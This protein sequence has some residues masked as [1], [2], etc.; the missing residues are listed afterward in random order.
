MALASN[1]NIIKWFRFDKTINVKYLEGPIDGKGAR[2]SLKELYYK[3]NSLNSM[4][5]SIFA[6]TKY[7]YIWN[8][9]NFRL[10]HQNT[11]D[12]AIHLLK[13]INNSWWNPRKQLITVG[14]IYERYINN[15]AFSSIH[16][17]VVGFLVIDCLV[18][19][20]THKNVKT[21]HF[22][23]FYWCF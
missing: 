6:A 19:G 20:S 17:Q 4:K 2:F 18:L 22:L 3:R 21:Q 15:W 11:L 5:I 1:W 7:L 10:A 13:N 14:F 8:L 12:S 16:K 9:L 23:H